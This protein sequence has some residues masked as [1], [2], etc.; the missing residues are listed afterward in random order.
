VYWLLGLVKGDGYFDDRHL[1]IYN[2]SPSVLIE[3]IKILKKKVVIEKIKA[4]IYTKNP[5]L[6][7]KWSNLLRLPLSN[8]KIRENTSE[9]ATNSEKLRIRV[10]SKNLV[11]EITK[12]QTDFW[13]KNQE[14]SYVK[15]LFD[16]EASVD[17]KGYIEFKQKA[18]KE[19]KRI[20]RQ[21]YNILKKNNVDCTRPRIK[22]DRVKEDCYFY[23]KDLLL[24]KKILGFA[25]AEKYRK[26][27]LVFLCLTSKR[28]LTQKDVLLYLNKPVTILQLMEKLKCSYHQVR[29]VLKEMESSGIIM[30]RKAGNQKVYLVV[31]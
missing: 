19:G 4:D 15:G 24:Y 3:A 2:S 1:E 21:I 20:V 30:S 12:L 29:K 16:A 10:A 26:L 11:S 22:R 28:I 13:D 23:V 17:I 7:S 8:I 31:R 14:L 5:N 27:E 9:W 25:D 6:R 18:T